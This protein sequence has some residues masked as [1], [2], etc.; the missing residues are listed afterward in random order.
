MADELNSNGFK[1]NGKYKYDSF[2]DDP[3]MRRLFMMGPVNDPNQCLS[4][5]VKDCWTMVGVLIAEHLCLSIV[6]HGMTHAIHRRNSMF[7]TDVQKVTEEVMV[8]VWTDAHQ[9]R[10]TN[11]VLELDVCWDYYLCHFIW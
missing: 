7:V 9:V 11:L 4:S 8:I 3:S 6:I 1:E 10:Q 2:E 5:K